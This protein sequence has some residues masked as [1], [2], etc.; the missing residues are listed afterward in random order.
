MHRRAYRP[1]TPLRRRESRGCE[2][3]AVAR[4]DDDADARGDGPHGLE[5]G[6]AFMEVGGPGVS[7]AEA[8]VAG[9][10]DGGDDEFPFHAV[11]FAA[12]EEME[13]GGELGRAEHGFFGGVGVKG[14]GRGA[15]AAGVH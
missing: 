9:E 3:V 13:E 12:G 4:E 14:L 1:L 15:V 11:G 10:G 2:L 7:G 5:D 8:P 6:L